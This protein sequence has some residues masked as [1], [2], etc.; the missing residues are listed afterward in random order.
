M[1]HDITKKIEQKVLKASE[2]LLIYNTTILLKESIIT[3]NID[4]EPISQLI[5]P[6]SSKPVNDF[7]P[8]L[9][10][11]T[12]LHIQDFVAELLKILTKIDHYQISDPLP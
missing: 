6:I 3:G 5:S 7:G 10:E 2:A 1:R 4:T 9:D 12:D 11:T 8:L